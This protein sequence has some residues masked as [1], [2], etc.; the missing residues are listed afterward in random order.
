MLPTPHPSK[1]RPFWSRLSIA[2]CVTHVTGVLI[3]FALRTL[4]PHWPWPLALLFT[5]AFRLN[6][7]GSPRDRPAPMPSLQTHLS[8]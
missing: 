7:D 2:F 3:F 5:Q 1:A 6:A 8:L 4:L